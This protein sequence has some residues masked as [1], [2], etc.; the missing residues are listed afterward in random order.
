MESAFTGT[1]NS[2]YT[3]SLTIND[4]AGTNILATDLAAIGSATT[5]SVTATNGI[6]ISGTATE[7]TAALITIESKVIIASPTSV[8]VS[9][10]I[11]VSSASE[12]A[13]IYNITAIFSGGIVDS[14]ANLTSSGSITANLLAI[15][16]DDADVNIT[17]IDDKSTSVKATELSSIGDATTGKVTVINAVDINGT[18]TELIAALI[19]DSTKVIANIANL[20]ISRENLPDL[21]TDVK[22]E[23]SFNFSNNKK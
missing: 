13:Q 6:A 22:K 10:S 7:V 9:D 5:G 17:I 20:M 21:P 14:I 12:I 19:T 11:T 4:A 18:T 15:T 23:L 8:D 16:N 2:T 3:G 1:F